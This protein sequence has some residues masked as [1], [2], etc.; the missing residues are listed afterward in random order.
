MKAYQ[1]LLNKINKIYKTNI[2][3]GLTEVEAN[4]RLKKYGK[5]ALPTVPKENIFHI[6]FRQFKS[7]LIYI[8]LISAVII[9]FLGYKMDAWIISIVLM[10]NAIIG[11]LSEER[12]LDILESLKTFV[13]TETVVLRNGEKKVINNEDLVVGDIIYLHEGERISADAR[14][15]ESNN[16]Q[17]DESILTGE[18]SAIIK[19]TEAIEG[20][21]PI[22]KQNNMVFNGT[23]ALLGN[24][25]AIVTAIGTGTEV[26]KL[27]ISL[28]EKIDTETPLKREYNRLSRWILLFIF[29]K[30][31]TSYI[32]SLIYLCNT[33]RFTGCTNFSFST[34][35]LYDG[36][37]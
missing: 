16:F 31:V 27:N 6:F 18:S 33:G 22:F 34:W 24:A 15:V 8:L 14:V 21:V 23:Y 5:N 1:I 12:S 13:K 7:P 2:E 32:S 29:I 9:F 3:L 35:C 25:K 37:E 26:G 11:T 19:K 10:F 28:T 4:Q 17:V 20:E 36:K 30:R